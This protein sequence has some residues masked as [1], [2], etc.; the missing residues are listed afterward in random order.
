MNIKECYSALGGNYD[1]VLGRFLSEDRVKK[2]ALKFLNDKSFENLGNGLKEKNYDEAFRAA[3]TIKG[4]CQNLSFT[5]LYTSAS[6]ITEELRAEKY[7]NIS[8]FYDKVKEDYVITKEALE[9][10]D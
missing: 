2:F 4:I 9:K 10:L 3:H 7:D 5:R 1:E 6:S 8:S